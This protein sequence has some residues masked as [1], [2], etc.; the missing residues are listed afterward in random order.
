[1]F[2]LDGK[3]IHQE[4]LIA[5]ESVEKLNTLQKILNKIKN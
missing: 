2:F 4:K 1:M 3:L 5:K